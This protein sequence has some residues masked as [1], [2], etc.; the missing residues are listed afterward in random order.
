MNTFVLVDPAVASPDTGIGYNVRQDVNDRAG[1]NRV[2]FPLP[3]QRLE[4]HVIDRLVGS[5]ELVVTNREVEFQFVPVQT[6]QTFVDRPWHWVVVS[7]TIEQTWVFAQD[8]IPTTVVAFVQVK[9]L[10]G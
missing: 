10:G 6:T 7:D 1:C 5:L 9:D 3:R 2:S 8:D 4:H